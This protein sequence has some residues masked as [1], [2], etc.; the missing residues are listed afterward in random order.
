M[1]N[2]DIVA[3]GNGVEKS[4]LLIERASCPI[5]ETAT[6]GMAK[7]KLRHRQLQQPE[8]TELQKLQTKQPN[9]RY[10]SEDSKKNDRDTAA[11]TAAAKVQNRQPQQRQLQPLQLLQQ[12]L[13]ANTFAY[14]VYI[15]Y[16]R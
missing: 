12:Q 5:K 11:K 1:D 6:I 8:Q 14:T 15:D 7:T 9:Q 13:A 4:C 10:Y 16:C 2:P 3:K